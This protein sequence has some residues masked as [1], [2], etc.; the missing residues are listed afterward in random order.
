MGTYPK[1]FEHPRWGGKARELYDDARRSLDEIVAAAVLQARGAY[2]FFPAAAVGD[3]IEV[4]ADAARH[5]PLATFH[6]LRQQSDKGEKEPD[7]SLADFVAPADLGIQDFL[8]AFAVTTGL[9]IEKVLRPY[10]A[11]HDDY[12]AIMVKALADRLAEAFAEWLHRKARADWGYGAAE[13]LAIDDL[14]RERYQGIRPAH[15]YPSCPDHTEKATLFSVLDATARTGIELT[16]SFAMMPASSV[17]GLYF[18]HPQSRYFAIQRVA[19][20]Q[21]L[22]YQRRKGMDLRTVERWLAPYLDYDPPRAAPDGAEAPTVLA[23]P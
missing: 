19:R 11:D 20:D 3:S 21:V 9:S 14:I 13:K 7:Q 12:G 22:D 4:F 10:E 15:G 5:R 8:G 17:S 2:G 1:I 16:D 18:S 23:V 6:M